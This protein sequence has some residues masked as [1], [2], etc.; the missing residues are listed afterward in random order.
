MGCSIG[1]MLLSVLQG[2]GSTAKCQP[3][4]PVT[5]SSISETIRVLIP[6]P[7][8]G[9]SEL[10]LYQSEDGRTMLDVWMVEQT[11]LLSQ[12][13]GRTWLKQSSKPT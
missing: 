3:E 12:K 7:Q 13:Q 4:T 11:V 5:K 8:P 9:S 10:S 6:A 2:D 1:A